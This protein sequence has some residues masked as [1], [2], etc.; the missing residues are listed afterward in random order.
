[1]FRRLIM[2]LVVALTVSEIASAGFVIGGFYGPRA[3]GGY[4]GGGSY[5]SNYYHYSAPSYNYA[6]PQ[7]VYRR[8]PVYLIRR[9]PTV[10]KV[11]KCACDAVSSAPA[12]QT[13][14]PSETLT[15]KPQTETLPAE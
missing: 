11:Q 9:K 12:V 1:M 13:V 15:P 2:T 7:I 4:Y 10:V 8:V 5:Y 6:P 14:V 3:G